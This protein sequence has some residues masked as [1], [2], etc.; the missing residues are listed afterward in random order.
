MALEGGGS[1]G[2]RGW[3]GDDKD[4]GA[5]GFDYYYQDQDGKV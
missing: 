4:V 1:G 3:G 5:G 2:W